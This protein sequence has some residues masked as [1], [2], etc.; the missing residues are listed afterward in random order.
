MVRDKGKGYCARPG[1]IMPSC[2]GI[3]DQGTQGF[4]CSPTAKLGVLSSFID[5]GCLTGCTSAG[6]CK[7]PVNCAAGNKWVKPCSSVGVCMDCKVR[8][9]SEGGY[10]GGSR[11]GPACARGH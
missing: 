4:K 10:E 3:G 5:P 8:A 9:R 6:G 1:A 7:A 11:V 2:D